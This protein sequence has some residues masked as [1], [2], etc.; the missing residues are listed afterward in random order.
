MSLIVPDRTH[1]P[2]LA[3][4]SPVYL[5]TGVCGQPEEAERKHKLTQQWGPRRTLSRCPKSRGTWVETQNT[6]EVGCEDRCGSRSCLYCL[7]CL[8]CLRIWSR[9]LVDAIALA[10]PQQLLLFTAL[11]G[12]WQ[13]DRRRVNTLTKYLRRD[14]LT[15]KMAWAIEPNPN[16]DGYHAHAWTHGDWLPKKHCRTGRNR[17]AWDGATS[18]LSPTTATSPTSSRTQLGTR[19]ACPLTAD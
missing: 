1:R 11:T 13:T 19:I 3:A 2:H 5:T 17:S 14:K 10:E 9:R 16:G 8:Y 12:N 6:G 4:A 18:A 15:F 7:Y